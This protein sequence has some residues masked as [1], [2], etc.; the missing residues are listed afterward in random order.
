MR[1]DF[2][3]IS[4][5]LVALLPFCVWAQVEPAESYSLLIY[6]KSRAMELYQGEKLLKTY[7]IGL[8]ANPVPPKEREGDRATPEGAYEICTKNPASKYHLALMLNYPNEADADR[9]LKTGL[10]SMGTHAKLVK[11]LREK[12][13]PDFKT[14]LGGDIEIHGKGSRKDWTWGCIALDNQDVEELYGI[15]PIGTKVQ[16]N[17]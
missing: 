6:K 12:Q 10:I 17:P 16:I 15:L 9:G 8:G 14:R 1:I 2:F 13:C 4:A 7:R 11:A 5:M 3:I